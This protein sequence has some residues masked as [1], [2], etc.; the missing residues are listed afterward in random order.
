MTRKA[1]NFSY[2]SSLQKNTS[3][4]TQ[5][6]NGCIKGLFGNGIL[7]NSCNSDEKEKQNV[8]CSEIKCY[9][10]NLCENHNLLIHNILVWQMKKNV[11][12]NVP[13]LLWSYKY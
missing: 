7:I 2:L 3:T 9:I 5:S 13:E 10:G 8:Y 6:K 1:N 12:A 11:A 4:P